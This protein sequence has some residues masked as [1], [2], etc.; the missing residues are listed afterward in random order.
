[1]NKEI[2][3]ELLK[4]AETL[5]KTGPQ[6]LPD[7]MKERVYLGIQEK[8]HQKTRVR[9]KWEQ[10]KP[11]YVGGLTLILFALFI[12]NLNPSQ[13]LISY[14]DEMGIEPDDAVDIVFE[15][16]A[17]NQLEKWDEDSILYSQLNFEKELTMLSE[18]EREMILEKVAQ[19]IEK[20]WS[21]I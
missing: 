3:S 11:V 9:K 5:P 7:G 2:E 19:E 17:E 10:W 14:S 4:W 8:I 20:E 12:W 18:K 21:E 15:T 13:P 6:K 16:L 1:M